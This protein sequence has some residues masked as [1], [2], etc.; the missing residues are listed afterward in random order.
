MLPAAWEPEKRD[1]F[2]NL[3][4][5]KETVENRILYTGQQYDQDTGS[6]I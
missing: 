3:L 5:Q 2:G 6:I 4:E 1:A